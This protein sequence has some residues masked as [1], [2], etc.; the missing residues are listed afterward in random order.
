MVRYRSATLLLL[1]FMPAVSA[2]STLKSSPSQTKLPS[3]TSNARLRLT[4]RY[5]NTQRSQDTFLHSDPR[6][7]QDHY[8]P[9]ETT[10][11][12]NA[13]AAGDI[14]KEIFFKNVDN[15]SPKDIL[16]EPDTTVALASKDTTET[17]DVPASNDNVFGFSA[18]KNASE[19]SVD[20]LG[21]DL[22]QED[23]TEN[24]QAV[25]AASKDA[26]LAA[27]ATLP[28]EVKEAFGSNSS[29]IAAFSTS[30]EEV[31]EKIVPADEVVGE[32][33]T[34]IA[35]E[36]PPVMKI[37]KFAVPAVC[38]WL[39][40]PLL[41]LIDTS[42]V[43]TLSGT[44]QQA[45]LSP[46]VAVTD[47]AALLV[48]FLYT[49]TTNLVAA[50]QESDRTVAGKP[51]TTQTMIG[52]M[53]LS[54]FVGV[55]IGTVL[56][57]FAKHLLR[58]I[59]GNDSI[60]PAVFAAA[61]KYVR[62]RALGMPAAAI[63][64]SAQAASLGMQDLRSPLYVLLAAAVVNFLG[65]MVFVGSKHPVIGG[66]AG[67][68]WATVFSQ[69]TA[70][71]IFIRW[72]VK[73]PNASSKTPKVVDL[74]KNI[75]EFMSAGN[76]GSKRKKLKELVQ[77]QKMKL[78]TRAA[79]KAAKVR[80]VGGLFGKLRS[81]S[82]KEKS[83]PTSLKAEEESFSVRGLLAGK[84]RGTDL[85]KFPSKNIAKE[86]SPYVAPVTVTQIG[87][88]SGYIAMSH[89]VSS[90]LGT[91][92]MAAQQVIV[93]FFYCLTPI[94]DS[95]SLTA[96]SFIPGI[97]ERKPSKERAAALRE[98]GINFLK[99]GGVFGGVMAAVCAL[100]PVLSGLFTAD[101]AVS[102][103]VNMVVPLLVAFFAVHGVLCAAE[104]VLLGQKDLG[105]L[106]KM[107]GAYF[108]AVPFFMLRV[109]KAALSGVQG[110]NLTSVW[111]VFLGYQMF[112]LAAWVAR[113]GFIQ[114]KTD[115]AAAALIEESF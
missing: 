48:A 58:A 18:L 111:T 61:M 106:G 26:A 2:F 88:V 82:K 69:Y 101:I 67:A 99:A 85:V 108:F 112:R 54:T 55:G 20:Q 57:V 59:I 31:V 30:V 33:V 17:V 35:I 60:D 4:Q 114:R 25:M 12:E 8:T 13:A 7:P 37:L 40:S 3:A 70:L 93:S 36:A 109:K 63:I 27:E 87:R 95:L 72:L 29:D 41:S 66:A 104:G 115:R 103:L 76:E 75:K 49:A 10:I 68:A 107:Y 42:A 32:P 15:T 71:A 113:V 34:R 83:E 38:V 6:G 91:I 94:A 84:F 47:Y 21:Y 90:S 16:A 98:T 56:L 81:N 11:S 100:M 102:G 77:A 50:A 65:D 110:I 64:G 78:E 9:V 53:Q 19:E 51:R 43:G 73:K 96:Q 79:K 22:Q 1:S 23:I 24:V 92:S 89:V 97:S 80:V 39:C 74:T 5:P 105:F 45:A 46:A 86:F 28:P 52:A 14:G 44:V 62:I